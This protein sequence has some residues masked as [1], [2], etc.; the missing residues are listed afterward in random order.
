VNAVRVAV[1]L[2]F[3]GDWDSVVICSF[4]ADLSFLEQDLWRQLHRTKNRIIFADRAQIERRLRTTSEL[5]RPRYLNRS[6]VVAPV[7]S[8]HSAHAKLILLLAAD[9]GLLAVGSGNLSFNGYAS[10]GECFTTYRWSEDD[11]TQMPAFVDVRRFL[12]LL[13]D[14]RA[15]EGV[16]GPRLQQA[17]S[18]APWIYRD[19]GEKSFVR[20]NLDRSHLDQLVEVIEGRRVK[21][22]VVH[23]PFYETTGVMPSRL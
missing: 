12:D 2:L 3:D 21:E 6:Y 19:A 9:E 4:G 23:A 16:I 15:V 14:R 18:D 13:V 20:H 8:D 10:Q 11:D 7:T 22:L 17:W 5:N 1:P